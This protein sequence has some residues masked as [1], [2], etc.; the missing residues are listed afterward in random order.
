MCIPGISGIA[1]P[2]QDTLGISVG[3][4]VQASMDMERFEGR[5]SSKQMTEMIE[6]A[7][8]LSRSGR[9]REG[10]IVTPG[11]EIGGR[12]AW[13]DA[14]TFLSDEKLAHRCQKVRVLTIASI[15]KMYGTVIDRDFSE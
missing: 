7:I 1:C 6:Q 14:G 4:D 15:G 13:R 8:G 9:L 3:P 12:D 10:S 11:I 2:L 5:I